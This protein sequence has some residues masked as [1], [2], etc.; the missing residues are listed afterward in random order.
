MN[1]KKHLKNITKND[2][3]HTVNC[4]YPGAMGLQ[5][6]DDIYYLIFLVPTV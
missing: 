4:M 1:A 5:D 3:H 2:G 6:P